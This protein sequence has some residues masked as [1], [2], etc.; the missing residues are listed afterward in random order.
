MILPE[1]RQDH[2]HQRGKAFL[3]TVALAAA[4]YAV[5]T[6]ASVSLEKPTRQ[7]FREV[8]LASFAP[9][10]VTPEVNTPASNEAETPEDAPVEAEPVLQDA[11]SQS[12]DQLDLSQ[13]FPDELTVEVDPADAPE[14]A[15]NTAGGD[16]ETKIEV[17]SGGL[18][19]LGSLD[20]LD[21]LG[22]APVPTSRGRSR[23][24]AEG[25]DGGISISSGSQAVAPD[26]GASNAG[27]AQIVGEN[28]RRAATAA[29]AD[30]DVQR[31][32]LDSFGNDYKNLEVQELI[33]W[34]KANP[35]ELPVGVRK[36]VRHR[37]QFLTSATTF[38]LDG[39]TYEL[40]LMCK[41]GLYE[42]H[43][44]LVEQNQATYLIDRSF[45][46]LSTYLREGQVARS[47][48]EVITAV[49]SRRT[50]ASDERSKEFYSLFLS[51]WEIAKS[52]S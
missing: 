44:V 32:S 12:L 20:G 34:M 16:S 52:G 29:E 23:R 24:P 43:I 50:A 15:R 9:P 3:T 30:F 38:A 46:K 14:S 4:A 26:Q 1:P 51:W 49:N 35:G 28:T 41:E 13:L 18:Q 37:D 39:T 31:L 11:N 27:S 36:L 8:D 2:I 10:V 21:A 19:G 45:Q 22:G 5:L 47:S 42:I 48:G 25:G 17:Q 7:I 40:F 6:F 33:D